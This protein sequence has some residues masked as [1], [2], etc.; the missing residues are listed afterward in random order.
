MPEPQRSHPLRPIRAR[1]PQ[2]AWA[3]V[4]AVLAACS[5]PEKDPGGGPDGPGRDRF[6]P[7]GGPEAPL[8]QAL[9]A[10]ELAPDEEAD[11]RAGELNDSA[12]AADAAP[13]LAPGTAAPLPPAASRGPADRVPARTGGEAEPEPEATLLALEREERSANGSD[14]ATPTVWKRHGPAPTIARVYVGD[15]NSLELERLRITVTVEGPR[16]RTVIDHVFRNP[17]EATLEGTF[18]YP[19][20]TGASPAYYAMFL[21]GQQDAIP[22]FFPAGAIADLPGGR[23]GAVAPAALARIADA[24]AWGELREARVVGRDQGRQVYEEIVRRSI[25]PALLEYASGNTFRGRVFPIQPMG[26]NRVLFAFEQHLDV[27]DGQV[28]YELPL[29][30]VNLG[31][32]HLTIDVPEALA[33]SI[34]V[35]DAELSRRTVDGRAVAEVAWEDAPAPGG[36]LRVDYTPADPQIQ[37]IAGA[38]PT[39]DLRTFYARFRPELPL[40]VDAPWARQA[41]FALDT[42]R[43]EAPDRFRRNVEILASILER[44][45]AI[46]RFRVLGFDVG[47]SWLGSD[48]WMPNDDSGRKQVLDALDDVLLEGATDLGN[49]IDRLRTADLG[50]RAPTYV[51]LLSDGE[52]NWG[53][54]DPRRVA[55]Q[56]EESPSLIP[57]VFCYRT[58]LS[59]E[60]LELFTALTR[61]GGAVFNA[62]GEDPLGSVALAHR[63]PALVIDHLAVT[64]DGAVQDLLVAGRQASVHPG[65]EV[66]FAGRG[67]NLAGARLEVRGSLDGEAKTWELPLALDDDGGL[68]ARGWAEIAV[69]QLLA[70]HDPAVEPLATAYAQRFQIASRV[71]SFLVLETDE[72]YERFGVEEIAG[73][74]D[75]PADVGTH[76]DE[77]YAASRAPTTRKTHFESIVHQRLGA[78]AAEAPHVLALL[79]A[80]DEADFALPPAL[81]GPVLELPHASPSYVRNLAA[82]PRRAATYLAE[83]KRRFDEDDP[84]SGMR[85]LSTV[86]EVHPGRSDALR[87]VGYRLLAFDQKG[88]AAWLFDRVLD[89]RPF[90]PHAW[91]D[92]ARALERSGRVA[93]A[94]LC[95]EVVLA[96]TWHARFE[97][98]GVVARGEYVQLLR[99]A[100]RTPG[101]RPELSALLAERL[102]QLAAAEAPAR[103]VV[104]ASWNTDST[105][106]DLWVV[107]PGGEAC[108]YSHPETTSGGALLDD[109]TGGYG[110]ERYRNAQAPAG[111]YAVLVHYFS[112]NP[113]L[114]AGESHV[115][116]V[117]TLDAG[118]DR[119]ETRRF[120]VVLG[121]EGEAHEVCL[122]R[123]EP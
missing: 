73:G 88:P 98:I 89:Q 55:R 12:I 66:I 6:T 29:P 103:L 113:N 122:V 40:R 5:S 7:G 60:N 118:T 109:L 13:V 8:A 4:L 44:D 16:A 72:D 102:E 10:G 37:A 82:H 68:A 90:E 33:A 17:H 70:L 105:D 59:A 24:D 34:D 26:L 95:Y 9:R 80:M 42:S 84:F 48:G 11:E 76:L 45:A 19:L 65:G 71:T 38:D 83:A 50:G 51:F 36:A 108:G 96:G 35:G 47:T 54:G 115:E 62:F 112:A 53:E 31:L 30:D 94:A 86:A 78:P 61:R 1:S 43:S 91:R 46:E 123:L 85:A 110:P 52:I 107:E 75:Q 15:G 74:T 111:E 22:E 119:A 106:V 20:P 49:A 57:R 116:I 39:S 77:L 67:A 120:T 97:S 81:R 117:V 3:A 101:Q 64:A 18:E 63:R 56:L 114:I 104:T 21:G 93:L 87:L 32:L 14:T 2:L 23:L 58:G 99:D 27:I 69:Q 79:A 25:D 92:L 100:V 28:R 121:E 41:V